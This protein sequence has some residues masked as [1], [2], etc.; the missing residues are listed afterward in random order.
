MGGLTR[1]A[2]VGVGTMRVFN[3]VVDPHN[4][5]YYISSIARIVSGPEGVPAEGEMWRAE[6][7]FL[8]RR[9]VVALRL[10]QLE[11]GRLVKF[12]IEGEPRATLTLHVTPLPAGGQTAISLRMEVPSVPDI[13][14]N[15]IMGNLL[16]ADM[17][18]LKSVL[19]GGT[20]K[21]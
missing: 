1:E 19:E 18:R 4:A 12:E 9:S 8:G 3:Y 11:V 21:E 6:V 17:S 15:A 5:P 14:L 20:H 2:V 13:F 10:A 16:S 7:N